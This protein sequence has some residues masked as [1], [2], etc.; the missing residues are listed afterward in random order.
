MASRFTFDGALMFGFRAAHAKSFPW[1]FALAFAVV[2]TVLTALF[3]WLTKDAIFGFMDTVE[4]LDSVGADDPA[5]VFS[6]FFSLFGGL[7]PW[8]VLGSLASLVVWAMFMA[9]TQRRYIRDEAFSI[10]FGPD[11]LRIMAVG[12][13][14]YLGVSL[15]YL[16]PGLVML[17]MFGIVS[18][19][20][21]GD[22]SENEMVAFMLGRMSIVALMFLV[23]FPVY[24][25]FA[26]RFSPVFA[27]TVKERRIAFGD[28]WIVS[29]GRFW[30][31]LGAFLILAIVGGMAVGF[32]GSIAQMLVTP[33]FMGSVSRV[34]DS[35]ELRSLFTP[36]LTIALLL[37]AFIRYFLSGLLMHF[38]QGPAA[39]AAR[40]DP[41]GSVDDALS[42]EE[43]N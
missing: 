25:F 22:I 27:M 34:E 29:R 4:Q 39:F 9:A 42:V 19:F 1:K 31:I 7:L 15:M 11:E 35:S 21:N 5:Q 32:A 43:F 23:M 28:A 10:R 37:Y 16:L 3:A 40:H 17:P 13:V 20:A 38:V 24:V 2:S 6:V 41:R 33:A 36:A 30:P 14:W 26:T 18:D 8:I 12:V